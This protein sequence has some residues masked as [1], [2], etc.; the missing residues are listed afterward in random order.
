MPK[1]LFLLT[2][3]FL[4]LIVPQTAYARITPEDILNDQREA[5]NQ[6]IKNYSPQNKQKLEEFEKKIA[7]F[8]KEKTNLL[9]ELME[10]QGLIL[11]EYIR[12]TGVDPR[13]ETDGI[14]RN[15]ENDVENT[16]Y[17]LTYAHEAVAFQAAKVY[18][19]NLTG[20]SNINRDINST[21]SQ[22]YAD[23][24]GLRSKVIKS[25][26]IILDLVD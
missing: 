11:D 23:L 26:K 1:T 16:R 17:W 25:Q 2:G 22:M 6:R 19:F 24:N 20:Q 9:G 4:L 21:I 5:Y 3:L 10:R 13:Y 8:N 12:R 15:L 18:V 7:D 14:K